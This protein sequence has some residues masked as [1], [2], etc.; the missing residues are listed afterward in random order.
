MKTTENRKSKIENAQ[1]FTLAELLVVIVII[2]VLAGVGVVGIGAAKKAQYK[3]VVRAELEVIEIALE[4]YKTKYG[5]YP[6]GNQLSGGPNYSPAIYSQLYYELAGTVIDGGNFVTLDG[7]SKIAINSV[8]N[9]FGVGGF[10]NCTKGSGED[11]IIAKNFLPSLKQKQFNT[12]VTNNNVNTTVLITSVS[13]PDQNYNPLN[14]PVIIPVYPPFPNP[15]RYVCPG[16]NNP[17][18]YDL[19][20]QLVISGQTNL[21]CNWSR[22]VII[23]SPL[24]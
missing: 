10:V 16:T 4:N 15:I 9:A 7:R 17:N 12:D 3:H 14:F 21:I 8:T 22:K 18:S 11:A 24:P 23:N 20:V 5:F 6:P 2:L 19:W 1:A 13:G